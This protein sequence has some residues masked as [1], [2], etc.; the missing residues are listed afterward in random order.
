MTGCAGAQPCPRAAV[1]RPADVW[2]GVYTL[3]DDDQRDRG[4]RRVEDD[5]E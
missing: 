5:N 1:R 2:L 4:A 3:W